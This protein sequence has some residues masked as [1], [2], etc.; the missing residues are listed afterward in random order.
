MRSSPVATKN[1]WLRNKD[2]GQIG[3]PWANIPPIHGNVGWGLGQS[4]YRVVSSRAGASWCLSTAVSTIRTV[5]M[6]LQSMAAMIFTSWTADEEGLRRTF[7]GYSDFMVEPP[8]SHCM[9]LQS[10]HSHSMINHGV[11]WFTMVCPSILSR[12]TSWAYQLILPSS[13]KTRGAR[14][15]LCWAPAVL[16]S[17]GRTS[18]WVAD[19]FWPVLKQ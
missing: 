7:K 11:T 10:S 4:P 19:R 5:N 17:P 1:H 9:S 14:S 18:S 12:G 8:L 2:L 3:K 6:E 15:E 13:L 16:T